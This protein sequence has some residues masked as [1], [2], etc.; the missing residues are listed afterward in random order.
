MP[1]NKPKRSAPLSLRLSKAQRVRLEQDAAGM[2]L[3]AYIKWRLF[4]PHTP[5]PRKR[6]KAPVKDH[7]ILGRLI[8][9]L[10]GSNIASNIEELASAVRTGSLLVTPETEQAILQSNTDIADMRRMLI[11]AFGLKE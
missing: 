11:A 1:N 9:L 5:P 6:G 4:D 10:G 8:A 7:V 2:S 3:S